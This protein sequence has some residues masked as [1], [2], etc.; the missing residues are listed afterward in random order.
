MARERKEEVLSDDGVLRTVRLE[1]GE[2]NET[3]FAVYQVPSTPAA[4]QDFILNLS[5]DASDGAESPLALA[6]RRYVSAVVNAARAE[7]YESIAQES[8]EINVGKNK[9]DLMSLPLV[10]VVK[11]YNGMLSE[12]ELRTINIPE[13]DEEAIKAVEKSMRF[14]PWR[15][16]V[17]KLTEQGKVQMN[18][19]AGVLELVG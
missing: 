8:T 5:A 15:T 14:G 4:F 17:R 11:A 3:K 16:A 6:Y 9:V 1:V 7:V 2:R 12:R 13:S 19:A 10:K 18:E